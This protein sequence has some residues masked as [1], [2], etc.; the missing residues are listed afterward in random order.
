MSLRIYNKR[1]YLK[2][3]EREGGREGRQEEGHLWCVKK[4]SSPAVSLELS[5]FCHPQ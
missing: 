5:L 2:K 4:P 3:E 1:S